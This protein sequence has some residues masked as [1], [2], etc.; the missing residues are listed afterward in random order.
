[1]AYKTLKKMPHAFLDMAGNF[2]M[3]LA[4]LSLLVSLSASAEMM[5]RTN[6]DGGIV[7]VNRSPAR[8]FYSGHTFFV[9]NMHPS[10]FRVCVAGSIQS[11][12][13]GESGSPMRSEGC[14]VLDSDCTCYRW[15][16]NSQNVQRVGSIGHSTAEVYRHPKHSNCAIVVY[17]PEA[18]DVTQISI[19]FHLDSFR[20]VVPPTWLYPLY[21][22]Y[23]Y[24]RKTQ[25]G[26][27]A[28]FFAYVYHTADQVCGDKKPKPIASTY[29]CSKR[30]EMSIVPVS[31]PKSGSHAHIII[32]LVVAAPVLL[33]M[34]RVLY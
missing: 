27:K 30:L 1:M 17:R 14:E 34:L 22:S 9:D 19:D 7:S 16:F 23:A 5:S 6:P 26:F 10:V 8:W 24:R 18:V 3:L 32:P 12:C 20:K 31:S 2:M 4:G 15:M 28:P 33:L 25:K 11:Q 13:L 29:A 21:Q